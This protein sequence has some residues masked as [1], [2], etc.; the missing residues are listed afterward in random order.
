MLPLFLLG[1]IL[2]LQFTDLLLVLVH[3]CEIVLKFGCRRTHV[4]GV[5]LICRAGAAYAAE[6]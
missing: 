2:P 5:V 4:E 6:L 1:R 3:L